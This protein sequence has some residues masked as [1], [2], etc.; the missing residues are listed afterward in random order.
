MIQITSIKNKSLIG[1]KYKYLNK[2]L[3][4]EI[5]VSNS[6][7]VIDLSYY[8]NFIENKLKYGSKFKQKWLD[9]ISGKNNI[10]ALNVINSIFEPITKLNKLSK[11]KHI[12]ILCK[13]TNTFNST[14][15]ELF[16]LFLSGIASKYYTYKTDII[17]TLYSIEIDSVDKYIILSDNINFWAICS[18]KSQIIYSIIGKN[19]IIKL[20]TDKFGLEFLSQLIQTNKLINKLR[21]SKLK[22]VNLQYLYLLLL[23]INFKYA[24]KAQRSYVFPETS[25]DIGASGNALKLLSEAHK[26]ISY[27]FLTKSDLIDIFL[28]SSTTHF[29]LN[30]S[31]LLKIQKFDILLLS[32]FSTYYNSSNKIQY[33]NTKYTIANIVYYKIVEKSILYTEL[34]N[35]NNVVR[36]KITVPT[37]KSNDN[38]SQVL[39]SQLFV[40]D[41][42]RTLA[43]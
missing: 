18:K 17:S 30:L 39:D 36:Q 23:Y 14:E 31:R 42:I 1:L 9:L 3:L 26:E 16:K 27:Y 43:W 6:I 22:Y 32:K 41:I 7:L 37:E 21:L 19:N 5:D 24:K 40:N 2:R 35:T 13:E 34:R 11:L 12:Y 20:Y 25:K 33:I 8:A 28:F 38:T 4:S 29:V 15:R 10:N